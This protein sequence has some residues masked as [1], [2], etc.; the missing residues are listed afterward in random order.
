MKTDTLDTSFLEDADK[1]PLTLI[2]TLQK[3][4]SDDVTQ[5]AAKAN[6]NT[7]ETQLFNKIANNTAK[8]IVFKAMYHLIVGTDSQDGFARR[9]YCKQAPLAWL[10]RRIE[11]SQEWKNA[12]D[13]FN[14]HLL[15]L[16]KK[17]TG[18]ENGN[19][20]KDYQI[21]RNFIKPYFEK[22]EKEKTNDRITARSSELKKVGYS[23]TAL[24][25]ASVF[26]VIAPAAI[27][28]STNPAAAI[29]AM[30]AIL[31]VS[32]TVIGVGLKAVYAGKTKQTFFPAPNKE[33]QHPENDETCDDQKT[34]N[35]LT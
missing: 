6:L 28:M 34:W 19:V 16:A 27:L 7:L 30:V 26:T 24:G 32:L 23:L 12:A 3:N 10:I 33:N 29:G 9:E 13:K 17:A 4:L 15:T 22:I 21:C 5:S 1:G 25:A 35:A 18:G 2:S 8:T 31:V 20:G 11:P 14:P